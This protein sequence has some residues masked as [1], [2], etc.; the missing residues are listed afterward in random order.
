MKFAIIGGGISGLSIANLLQQ[1][2]HNVIVFEACDRPGGL[3]KC[4]NVNGSLFHLTGGHVFNS[5]R[6]DVIEWFWSFFDMER[7][8]SLARRNSCVIMPD[9]KEIPYPIE[10]HAY[11]LETNIGKQI[12]SDWV[13]ILKDKNK[14]EAINFEDFLIRRFGKTLYDVYF[15]PYNEKVWQCDLTKVPLSWLEGKLP[16]PTVEEM[17]FNNIYHIKENSFVHSSFYYP[18]K[19]GSQFIAD[20]IAKNLNIRYNSQVEVVSRN[21]Q[22]RFFLNP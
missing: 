2:G 10:N 17:L 3:I 15:K 12:I 21:P 5:K 9:G 11:M 14:D 8:F 18:L 13:G 19:G 7:D 1:N 6:Q 22:G 16:M 20:T 4:K